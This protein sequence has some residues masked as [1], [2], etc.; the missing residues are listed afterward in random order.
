M[1]I[2]I[3]L[4]YLLHSSLW[5][6]ASWIYKR[7]ASRPGGYAWKSLVGIA[8]AYSILATLLFPLFGLFDLHRPGH[9]PDDPSWPGVVFLF[10]LGT[11]GLAGV[12]CFG[13]RLKCQNSLGACPSERNPITPRETLLDMQ[14][15]RERLV[16]LQLNFGQLVGRIV[17]LSLTETL[18]EPVLVGLNPS[19]VYV[20]ALFA[21]EGVELEILLEPLV[22]YSSRLKY[23]A[24]MFIWWL[25]QIF[26]LLQPVAAGVRRAL[27][28]ELLKDATADPVSGERYLSAVKAIGTPSASGMPMGLAPISCG[29]PMPPCH[30]R[31][32]AF[33]PL[34]GMVAFCGCGAWHTGG[35]NLQDLVL[36]G[37]Q[38]TG[39]STFAYDPAVRFRPVQ[40]DGGVLP[41]G[42]LVDT[43]NDPG[44][45]G[46]S[47]LRVPLGL[48]ESEKE[49]PFGA[50]AIRVRLAWKTIE[51][52]D[53]AEEMPA[54]KIQCSEQSLINSE[55]QRDLRLF[56]SRNF[57]IPTAS[58]WQ[59]S[60]DI[61]LRVHPEKR[62]QQNSTDVIYGPVIYIP[63]GWKMVWNNYY[64]EKIADEEVDPVPPDEGKRFVAWYGR[65]GARP[66]CPDFRWSGRPPAVPI[67]TLSVRP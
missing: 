50:N 10:Y 56:F 34:V 23:R 65:N 30:K 11:Q 53:N 2:K 1:S 33:F 26:I 22:K 29:S 14:R 52:A 42:I 54:V 17:P 36:T 5:L 41:D 61:S 43:R 51:K 7:W 67:P 16:A 20:P 27:E 63:K 55:G 40:E 62:V 38:V 4:Y 28:I 44:V 66:A 49:I 6:G 39:Y 57:I 46:C 19:R 3:F 8:M 47:T 18:A 59:G 9:D 31:P 25:G 32:W 12:I 48:V 64:I 45:A 60:I 13:A 15:A 24:F 35:F 21:M 37:R 58:Q